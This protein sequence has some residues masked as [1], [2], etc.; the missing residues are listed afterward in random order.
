[1][2]RCRSWFGLTY[3]YEGLFCWECLHN[4]MT[5]LNIILMQLFFFSLLYIK[6]GWWLYQTICKY[7]IFYFNSILK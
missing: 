1:M 3:S 4:F 6:Y 5:T 2:N 7:E